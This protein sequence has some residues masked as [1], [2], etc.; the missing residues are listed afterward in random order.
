LLETVRNDPNAAVRLKAVEGLGRY[1]DD[2]ATRDGLVFVLEHDENAGVRSKAIDVLAPFSSPTVR[3]S[4][5]LAGA[6]A[7]V[8]R[9]AQQ[10]DYVRVR[11]AALL[12]QIGSPLEVY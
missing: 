4:P 2:A 9:S 6:L 8:M 12:R 11:C 3:I 7:D 10:D 1:R 5:D